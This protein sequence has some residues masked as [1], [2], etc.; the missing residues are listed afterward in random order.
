MVVA[1]V[2]CNLWNCIISCFC[3][4]SFVLSAS[5]LASHTWS[6]LQYSSKSNQPSASHFKTE[7][8]ISEDCKLLPC[9]W[10][11]SSSIKYVAK[12]LWCMA[13]LFVHFS[14]LIL[15]PAIDTFINISEMEVWR[16]SKLF[17]KESRCWS[18]DGVDQ[19]W[20]GLWVTVYCFCWVFTVW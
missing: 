18:K 12:H 2:T 11:T 15:T 9:L 16:K 5:T 3:D 6:H 1:T 17:H 7:L 14:F 10:S 19:F 13:I 8:I 20:L 4:I